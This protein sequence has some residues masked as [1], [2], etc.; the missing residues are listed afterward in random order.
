MPLAIVRGGG[1][2][3]TG[4]IFRLWKVGFSVLVL[5]AAQP[6]MVRRTVSVAQAV[7]DGVCE[8]EGMTARLISA[9]S[10]WNPSEI[11]VLID[12]DGE[13]LPD[14]QP[15]LLVDAIMAKRNCGTHR[16][17]APRVLALG[18]GFQAPEEVHA[19][20]ETLRGHSLG[21]VI[22][23]G[24]AAPDTGVPGE[25]GGATLDRLLRAPAD[26]FLEPLASIGDLVEPGQLLGHVAGVELRSQL[27]GVLRGLIH[28]SVPVRQGMKIGDVDPRADRTL[29]FSISDKALAIAGGVLEAAFAKR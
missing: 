15:D 12:P 1:D 13:S 20:I 5:E 7:F 26:G 28:P 22:T 3:A 27:G 29:C 18:P 8:I 16:D 10:A 19:V 2:L 17:M 14:L 4:V 11:G 24:R 6:T 23:D 9:P 21:R 25:I